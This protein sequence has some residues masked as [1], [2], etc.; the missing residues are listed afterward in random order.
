MLRLRATLQRWFDYLRYDFR[1]IVVPRCLPPPPDH[2]EEGETRPWRELPQVLRDTWRTYLDTW[3]SAPNEHEYGN[4]GAPADGKKQQEQHAQ[5]G[6]GNLYREIKDELAGVAKGGAQ[7]MQPYLHKLAQI[8]GEM[9]KEGI[10]AFTD[11]YKAGLQAE[12]EARVPPPTDPGKGG[13]APQHTGKP[14]GQ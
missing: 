3:R 5:D 2:K 14:A 6:G 13:T 9:V 7:G 11:G 12:S 10:T 4:D 1:D 8:R